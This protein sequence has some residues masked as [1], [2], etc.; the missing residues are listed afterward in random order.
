M[1]SGSA[2]YFFV[3]VAGSLIACAGC[4]REERNLR[5]PPPTAGT[6][7]VTQSSPLFPGPLPAPGSQTNGGAPVRM[8]VEGSAYEL[9]EGKRLY[10]AY[11]CVGCHAN[12]GG[13]MGP[14][15]MD[16]KWLYGIE[17]D[18]VFET[19]VKGRPN[20]MP[21]FAGKIPDAQVWQIVGYVRSLSGQLSANVA[22][23]RD[24]HMNMGSPENSRQREA[25]KKITP[26][27]DVLPLPATRPESPA[28]TT[29]TTTSPAVKKAVATTKA[30]AATTKATTA[31]GGKQ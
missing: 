10:A 28:Q 23:S 13:G 19:I 22:S 29:K 27:P 1:T 25:A 17:P 31:P 3:A 5:P 15:L 14:A 6:V 12:G 9:S 8:Y 11:N 18:T 20:G 24:E 26:P 2:P 4:E 21:S 30:K 16:D 7:Y